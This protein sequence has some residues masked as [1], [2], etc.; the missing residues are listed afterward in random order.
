[1]TTLPPISPH[2]PLLRVQQVAHHYGQRIALQEASFDLWPGEVL[3]V[4]GESGSGKT[5]LLNAL[6]ARQR[7]AHGT[8]EFQSR[9]GV[10]LD[11]HALSEAQQ[12]LLAR[13]D[14]GFV[15]QNP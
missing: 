5:T 8:V 7:P 6:S 3:A 2:L 14:W 13:T 11:V 1:M 15:H 12:R 10:L 9:D 4:V